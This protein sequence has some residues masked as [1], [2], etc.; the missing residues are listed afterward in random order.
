MARSSQDGGEICVNTS[1][2]EWSSQLIPPQLIPPQVW[3]MAVHI[4]HFHSTV[5]TFHKLIITKLLSNVTQKKIKI[6]G[7]DTVK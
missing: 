1:A 5:N 7:W 3:Q 2:F 6:K 4:I